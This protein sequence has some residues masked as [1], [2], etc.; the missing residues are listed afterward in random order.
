MASKYKESFFE[1]KRPWSIYKDHILEFYLKPYL[2]KVKELGKPILIVDMFAGRGKFDTGEDGSPVIIAKRM[3]ES[4]G[5]GVKKSLLCYESWDQHFEQLQRELRPYVFAEAIHGNCIADMGRIAE[6]AKTHTVLLYVDPC[7]PTDLNM[8]R[9]AS[10][11]EHVPKSQSS[12]EVLLVFMARGFMRE[13]S[14]F[15]KSANENMVRFDKYV[16]NAENEEEKRMW[17]HATFSSPEVAEAIQIERI[18]KAL[19]AIAGG[20]Y[21]KTIAERQDVEW[22][23]K[24]QLL[25]EAYQKHMERWFR[26]VENYPIRADEGS[27]LPKYWIVFGSRYLPAIDFFNDAACS[28][29][30]QQRQNFRQPGSLFANTPAQKENAVDSTVDRAVLLTAKKSAPCIWSQLRWN[31]YAN[32]SVGLYTESEVNKSIKRLLKSGELAGPNGT[33]IEEDA[34]IVLTTSGQSRISRLG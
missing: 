11:Y 4:L 27:S 34:K 18:D 14:R 30:R 17:M 19:T 12:V 16:A 6:L 9:L 5:P 23:E 20:V 13:A 10:V 8:S 26:L 29:A 2:S 1:Q 31:T 3:A 28:A 24:C 25:V 15:V 7:D 22:S 32:R 33:K 21:W